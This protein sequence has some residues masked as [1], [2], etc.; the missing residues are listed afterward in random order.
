MRLIDNSGGGSPAFVMEE[1]DRFHAIIVTSGVRYASAPDAETVL[2]FFVI[3]R[4][5]GSYD[6]VNVMKTFKSGECVSRNVQ[7]KAGIS[8]ERINGEVAAVTLVFGQ[9]IEQHAGVK[10][11]WH[12]LDLGNVESTAEQVRQIKAWGRVGVSMAAQ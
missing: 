7:T 1:N 5:S 3:R 10:L 9:A 2:T 12:R 4:E 11:D 8:Q 6:I